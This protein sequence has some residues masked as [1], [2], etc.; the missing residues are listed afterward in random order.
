VKI[1]QL[2][3]RVPFPPSDGGSIAMLNLGKALAQNGSDVK[4]LC[5]NTEK[6]FS[7][8]TRLPEEIVDRFHPEAV[9]INTK[10]KIVPA[11]LNIFGSGSYN[12]SRF[13]SAAFRNKLI[14]ILDNG[15]FDCVIIES[16]FM[17]PY[18]ETIHQHSNIPVFLR[19][20]NVEFEIWNRLAES[21]YNPLK[22]WYLRFLS[23]RLKQYETT[24][25]NKFDGLIC[26]TAQ[27][28][29]RFRELGCA[30][31]VHIA[32]VSIDIESYPYNSETHPD[33]SAF[34]LGS[35]D[36]L[37]N[38]EG[39]EWFIQ[40]VYPLIKNN[41][42]SKITLA[43]KAMPERL[44][45]LDAEQLNVIGKVDD[46]RGFM[47]EKT[48]ML[49]PLLSGGGMRVKIVEGMA[50]GKVIISTTLGAEGIEH[51]KGESILIADTP[52]QFANAMIQ[53]AMNPDLCLQIGANARAQAKLFYDNSVIGTAISDFIGNIV[54]DKLPGV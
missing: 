1:L 5:L 6:H 43:G 52:E 54:K 29:E 24:V 38:I 22:K 3:L 42:P 51:K 45:K 12:V 39:V 40:K 16:I 31:P 36:W 4:M 28:A 19:A 11:L 13:E 26:I 35:M 17:A 14:E 30:I 50:M 34:H 15:S 10:V 9:T 21:E 44:L 2:C 47:T 18:L 27:D 53:M 33:G 46:A 23:E 41:Y 48:I 7:E 32:P 25:L 20:H 37:P 49:V 8:L